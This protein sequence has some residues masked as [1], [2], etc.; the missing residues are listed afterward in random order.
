MFFNCIWYYYA[1]FLSSLKSFFPTPVKLRLLISLLL[2]SRSK[3]L[4]R[5]GLRLGSHVSGFPLFHGSSCCAG[6][7]WWCRLLTSAWLGRRILCP[8]FLAWGPSPP[9]SPPSALPSPSEGLLFWSFWKHL[10]RSLRVVG[11]FGVPRSSF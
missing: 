10:T 5:A 3:H 4:C 11:I 7:G 9:G 1:G 8:K 6:W 2:P